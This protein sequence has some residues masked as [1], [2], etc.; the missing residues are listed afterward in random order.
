MSKFMPLEFIAY[1]KFFYNEDGTK[2]QIRNA[3]GYYK[4]TDTGS[5][6]FDLAWLHH[7]HHNDHHWQYWTVVDTEVEG[8]IKKHD[9][10]KNAIREMICDWIG[11]GKAQGTPDTYRWYKTNRDKMI[12]S[13]RTKELIEINLSNRGLWIGGE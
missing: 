1:A 12:I 11:A 8:N 7:T 3:T 9:M 5:L 13:D 4:P 2:K 10:P 6:D